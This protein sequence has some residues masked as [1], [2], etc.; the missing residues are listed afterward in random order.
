MNDHTQNTS[1][2][3]TKPDKPK[4]DPTHQTRK[5]T[6]AMRDVSNGHKTN[7]AHNS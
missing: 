5:E 3:D 2:K 4:E 7:R 1:K 6:G